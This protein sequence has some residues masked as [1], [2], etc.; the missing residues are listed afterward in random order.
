MPTRTLTFLKNQAG[1]REGLADAGIETFRDAPYASCARESGQNARDAEEALP[2]QMRFN[3]WHLDRGDFPAHADLVAAL[4]ACASNAE[5]EGN[6]KE[7]EFFRNALEVAERDKIPVLEIADFNTR[8]LT[9]PPGEP[10]T[11]FHSLL[12]STG[13]STKDRD[14]SGGSFGI[15]KNATFAVSDLQFVLYSSSY[16]NERTGMDEVAAQGKIRL[17][18]HIDTRG[19]ERRATGYWGK[20]DFNAI[21][22]PADIPSWM[23]RTQR[24]TSIFAMGFRDTEGWARLITASLVA[25]FFCAVWRGEMVFEVG[26]A[27]QINQNTIEDLLGRSEIREAAEQSGHLDDLE[28]AGHLFRALTSP[29]A[30]STR[31][32]I[33]DLGE[34]TVRVLLEPGLPKRIGFVRNGMYI[35]DQLRNFGHPLQRFSGQDF[36]ALVEPVDDDA[37]KMLKRLENP[38]HD[39]FS[40]ERIADPQKRRRVIAAMRDLG[41][42]LRSLIRE[43]TAIEA[44]DSIVLDE[45]AP[46]FG[47]PARSARPPLPDAESDPERFVFRPASRKPIKRRIPADGSGEEGGGARGRRRRNDGGGIGPGVGRG[48]GGRGTRGHEATASLVEVRNTIQRDGSGAARGRVLYFTPEDDGPIRIALEATGI[49]SP[50]RL[51]VTKAD[52]GQLHDGAVLLDVVART[53]YRL[54]IQLSVDYAGPID[55]VA[56]SATREGGDQS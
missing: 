29:V 24:G 49:D 11:P 51:H 7:I 8:G 21:T 41:R 50:E 33:P 43:V 27:F 31:L 54:Q 45:L 34:L 48:K 1:E 3:V 23:Q 47:E 36:V 12:K 38:R 56:V 2:V 6:E 25:N 44:S 13:V 10:G 18:S 30:A 5:S 22:S 20:P 4:R 53:R 9:G 32:N 19:D 39:D 40:G 52:R 17:A 46:F 16:W 15:G 35:T 14:T 26:K 42:Q 55:V 37:R 28:F